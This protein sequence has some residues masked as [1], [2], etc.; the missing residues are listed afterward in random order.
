MQ[1]GYGGFCCHDC[2]QSQDLGMNTVGLHVQAGRVNSEDLE[3][4]GSQT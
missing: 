1:P 2:H 4:T 3:S